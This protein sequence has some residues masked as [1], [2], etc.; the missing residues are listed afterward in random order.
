MM[1]TYL[2]AVAIAGFEFSS[3]TFADSDLMLARNSG[4]LA[5]HSINKKVIGPAWKDV[6]AKYKDQ[7]DAR[8]ALI[9]KVMRGGKGNWGQVPMPPYHLHP[10][11]R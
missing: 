11:S 5:C 4:C 3:N 10:F 2:L 8:A 7:P 1:K 9:A 6:A